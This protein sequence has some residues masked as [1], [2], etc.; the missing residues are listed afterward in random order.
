[1]DPNGRATANLLTGGVDAI[2]TRTTTGVE[3][4]LTDLLGSD[5]IP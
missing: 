4:Y 5:L 3:N 1:M 2:F